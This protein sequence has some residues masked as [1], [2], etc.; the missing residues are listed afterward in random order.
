MPTHVL[1]FA[2]QPLPGFAKTRL[3]P[4]LGEAGAAQLAEG[5]LQHAVQ[6]A[7]A[8]D[9]GPVSLHFTPAQ[10]PVA[11]HVNQPDFSYQPQC[12][13][14]L[15][16]RMAHACGQ[17]SAQ[18]PGRGVLVM[19]TDCPALTSEVL[20]QMHSALADYHACLVPANDGGY[21]ALAMRECQAEVFSNIAWSTP[22]VAPTTRQRMQALG[23]QWR[24]LPAL[25]DID[26]AEDLAYLSADL[27]AMVG[28]G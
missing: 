17:I 25:V 10:W 23:W 2:K 15:G 11:A 12:D 27:K 28:L 26:E 13:G 18:N 19:G 9:I 20:Q 5:L 7:K 3:I 22:A 4:A 14:D 6:Q 24:E 1:I 8:A 21:V 16:A